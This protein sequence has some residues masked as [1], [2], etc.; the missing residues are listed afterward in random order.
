MAL[1]KIFISWPIVI[2]KII[3]TLKMKW[4]QNYRQLVDNKTLVSKLKNQ[5]KK[6]ENQN[7]VS[8][9]KQNV[10]LFNRVSRLIS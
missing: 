6:S 5:T 9:S 1:V 4:T 7:L 2:G 8:T 3:L 10:E